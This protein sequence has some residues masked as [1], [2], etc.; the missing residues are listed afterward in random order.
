MAKKG[1]NQNANN[2][3]LNSKNALNALAM[4]PEFGKN[5]TQTIA[6]LNVQNTK[7]A[8]EFSEDLETV[9]DWRSGNGI[10]AQMN[11]PSNATARVDASFDLIK[12]EIFSLDELEQV[13]RNGFP[14]LRNN[15]QLLARFEQSVIQ[16]LR[17]QMS[18]AL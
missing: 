12:N 16:L 4:N 5:I 10:L 7:S 3:H 2:P 9:L 6:V 17:Q 1:N 11:N 13:W 15:P 14:Q 8:F 18:Q